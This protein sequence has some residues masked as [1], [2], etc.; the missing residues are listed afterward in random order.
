[1]LIMGSI[2]PTAARQWWVEMHLIYGPGAPEAEGEAWE[3]WNKLDTGVT[4]RWRWVFVCHAIRLTQSSVCV[5][6]LW[7]CTVTWSSV[8]CWKIKKKNVVICNAA[9]VRLWDRHSVR[10]EREMW[11][12]L[13]CKSD[14]G[15]CVVFTCYPEETEISTENHSDRWT[16][17]EWMLI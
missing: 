9:V 12:E 1:M 10:R 4:Y 2:N 15:C 7:I 17:G 5:R 11:C 3:R 6:L 13:N 14:A 8:T 16:T